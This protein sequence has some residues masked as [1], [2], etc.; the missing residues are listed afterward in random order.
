MSKKE[1]KAATAEDGAAEKAPK[2]KKA[3]IGGV[4]GAVVLFVAGGKVM[5]TGETK[6]VIKIVNTTTTLPEGKV[7]ALDAITM[8]LSDGH[9]LKVGIGFQLEY[10]KAA[11]GG[12]GEGEAAPPA[13]TTDPTKGYA[14]ALDIVIDE[15][16]KHT[17]EDLSGP[18]RSEAKEALVKRLE[19]TF[20]GKIEDVYFHQFVMQ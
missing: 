11:G 9:L 5:G 15:L 3:L 19:K 10:E 1:K 17:M 7:V 2:S 14:R 12:G 8:N 16:G 4:V 13:D 6:T 18:G 20:H